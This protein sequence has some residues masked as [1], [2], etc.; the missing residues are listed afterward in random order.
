MAD[1]EHKTLLRIEG[2]AEGAK[3][4]AKEAREAVSGVGEA[5]EASGKKTQESTVRT[6]EELDKQT[7]KA[8]DGAKGFDDLAAGMGTSE[9]QANAAREALSRLSPELG[10]LMEL[11]IKG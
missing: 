2:D 3:R 9:Q 6:S 4:A 1:D 7:K 5:T 10:A 8:Q 11:G